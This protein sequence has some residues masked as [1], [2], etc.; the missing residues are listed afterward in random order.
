[1]LEKSRHHS[2]GRLGYRAATVVVE[3]YEKLAD[4][5]PRRFNG[6]FTPF[7]RFAAVEVLGIQSEKL[8]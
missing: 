6:V 5:V 3:K 7:G 1:M 8:F 2:T 4:K